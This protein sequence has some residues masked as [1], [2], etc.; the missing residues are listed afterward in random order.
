MEKS[1]A[2]TKKQLENM[3]LDNFT[4]EFNS[5]DEV[6]SLITELLTITVKKGIKKEDIEE[7][8]KIF[9]ED[10][11]VRRIEIEKLRSANKR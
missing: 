6:R 9:A 5:F 8:I 10:Q 3:I 1:W 7:Y 4:G 11:E 2:V